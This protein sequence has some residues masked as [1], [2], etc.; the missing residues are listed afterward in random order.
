MD[1]L[2]THGMAAG[3]PTSP[4]YTPRARIAEFLKQYWGLEFK[5]VIATDDVLMNELIDELGLRW[6]DLL[7]NR[8]HVA[9]I[10]ELDTFYGRNLPISFSV[11]LA[12]R[13]L[14]A[15][16][17]RS[18]ARHLKRFDSS[19]AEYPLQTWLVEEIR[20]AGQARGQRGRRCPYVKTCIPLLT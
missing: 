16:K 12:Q 8:Q 3:D 20:R 17:E 14:T 6:V 15:G 13:R 11:A 1:E 4:G 10:S 5:N 7:N 9:L 18:L 2:L 19:L